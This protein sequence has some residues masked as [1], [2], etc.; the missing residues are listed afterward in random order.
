MPE[1]NFNVGLILPT[2]PPKMG[3]DSDEIAFD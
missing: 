3:K 1:T 2:C